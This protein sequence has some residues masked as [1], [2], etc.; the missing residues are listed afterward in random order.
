MGRE[1][2]VRLPPGCDAYAIFLVAQFLNLLLRY[3]TLIGLEFY[4]ED[5]RLDCQNFSFIPVT[6]TI[7]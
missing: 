7:I 5:L 4:F 3:P 1:G 6:F 2:G